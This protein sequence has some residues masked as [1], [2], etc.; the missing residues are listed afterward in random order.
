VPL[1]FTTCVRAAAAAAAQSTEQRSVQN[2][3]RIL[4]S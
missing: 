4:V 1:P 3:T 2:W